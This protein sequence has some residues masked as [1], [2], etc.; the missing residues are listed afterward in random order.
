MKLL[1]TLKGFSYV[2]SILMFIKSRN[3][4]NVT[5][6]VEHSLHAGDP[7]YSP[8]TVQYILPYLKLNPRIFS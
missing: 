2:F 6:V 1:I 3:F 5:L 7:E 4:E 8:N